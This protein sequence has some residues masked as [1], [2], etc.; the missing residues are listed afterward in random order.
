MPSLLPQ[1]LCQG[2][3]SL[4][5]LPTPVFW[6]REFHGLY[7]PWGHKEFDTIEWVLC[8]HS[9][10]LKRKYMFLVFFTD[11]FSVSW[12]HLRSSILY[13]WTSPASTLPYLC[14][15]LEVIIPPHST[16]VIPL[17]M[18]LSLPLLCHFLS[19]TFCLTATGCQH[20][21]W[22]KYTLRLFWNQLS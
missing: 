14:V 10:Y 1:D 15:H 8:S 11:F 17:L 2:R 12:Q 3:S 22:N 16:L 13:P 20:S 21:N 19:P 4:P 7:S 6:P 18:L 9:I 5:T